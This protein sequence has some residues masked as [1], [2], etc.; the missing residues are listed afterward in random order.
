M[1][2]LIGGARLIE[3]VCVASAVMAWSERVAES[4]DFTRDELAELTGAGFAEHLAEV[5]PLDF[6]QQTCLP[7]LHQNVLGLEHAFFIK[8]G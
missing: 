4:H 1:V 3:S 5:I 8:A 2:R 7:R 6:Q